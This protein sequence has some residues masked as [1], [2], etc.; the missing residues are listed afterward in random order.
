M[1][2]FGIS[3]HRLGSELWAMKEKVSDL[4]PPSPTHERPLFATGC[5][6][7]WVNALLNVM[8]LNTRSLINKHDDL[9]SLMMETAISW[10][11]ISVSE[12]WLSKHI[13]NRYNL[14]GSKA[15]FCSR[16]TGAAGGGSGTI[17]K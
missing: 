16:K 9:C 14:P 13:E 11:L 8:H 15:Y 17:H 10:H 12:T 7:N 2:I 6:R 4:C 5:G 1:N 3:E